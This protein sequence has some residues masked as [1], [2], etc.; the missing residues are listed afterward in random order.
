MKPDYDK[1]S[2]QFHGYLEVHI[3]G[4]WGTVCSDGWDD[5][6]ANI[7]CREM[8]YTGGAAYRPPKNYS[9]A[10]L[11]DKV[12]CTGKEKSLNDCSYQK[13]NLQ[14]GCNFYSERAGVFC[15]NDTGI[16]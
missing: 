3:E 10:I 15:F 13:W 6:A 7:A 8:G 9:S 5:Q 1:V 4:I 14:T 2:A 11:M 16:H 12:K